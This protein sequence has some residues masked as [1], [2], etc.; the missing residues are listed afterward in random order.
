[1]IN[2]FR[3]FAAAVLSIV[4]VGPALA[5][6]RVALVVGNGAYQS[7]TPLANPRS[8]ATAMAVKLRTL[9][10]E[11][12]EGYDV[13]I[14]TLQARVRDFARALRGVDVAL[15]YYAGHGLGID[16][17]NYVVPVDAR[18]EDPTALAFEAVELDTVLSQMQLAHGVSLVF[19]DA[20]RDN[21]MAK[22][23]ARSLKGTSRST[24]VGTGLAAVDIVEPGR[25]TA[26]AFATSPGDV[27]ADGDGAHSPFTEALLRNIDRPNTSIS[28]VM[29]YVT[30]EV[31]AATGDAQRPWLNASLTGPVVLNPV[32]A[33]PAPQVSTEDT[34]VPS[35]ATDASVADL[36]AQKALFDVALATDRPE[37]YRAYL[38]RF[39]AGLFVANARNALD[40]T[41]RSATPSV[42][43]AVAGRGS[44]API[45]PLVLTPGERVRALVADAAAEA[46]L[47]M[48]RA[49]RAEVQTRLNLS[50]V[51]GAQ[52]G[53]PD[54]S[55]GTGTRRAI[56]AWQAGQGVPA[57]GYIN[58]P[59]L[60]ILMA[61][62]DATYRGWVAANPVAV[63][64]PS[65]PAP[66]RTAKR[67]TKPKVAAREPQRRS[68]GP[69]AGDVIGEV[70][71]R[72]ILDLLRH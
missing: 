5:E 16:G 19:L 37:D 21:P 71:T 4:L 23:L 46:A 34:A 39:P 52:A 49:K 11:V 60:E 35:A 44:D 8:D 1:M 25:G 50:G 24:V 62:T 36:Q 66:Q 33:I 47:E 14:Y 30:G 56:A 51:A 53:K 7:V 2:L 28:E 10:F 45:E 68:S 29:S 17:R 15:F 31:R 43:P 27:A 65:T 58:A 32:A 9:G 61:S 67:P 26:I 69:S 48:D 6:R 3:I 63:A 42:P 13:D 55:F 18:F 40:R 22:S 54:G 59:Q 70:G 12:I 57:S 72:I 64:T 20:C 41:A 38:D